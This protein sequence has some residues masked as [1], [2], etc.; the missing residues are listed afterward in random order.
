MTD[1]EREIVKRALSYA[2]KEIRAS[3]RCVEVLANLFEDMRR[4]LY[5]QQASAVWHVLNRIPNLVRIPMTPPLDGKESTW[6]QSNLRYR[7]VFME[8]GMVAYEMHQI[9]N[10]IEELSEMLSGVKIEE[11]AESK[12][13]ESYLRFFDQNE[14]IKF[15]FTGFKEMTPERGN[16]YL[17]EM[18]KSPDMPIREPREPIK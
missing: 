14:R 1:H 6:P 8:H 5:P 17:D 16:P 10:A 2:S 4:E 13:Y 12:G 3:Q 11:V 9:S 7:W 18:L 15:G